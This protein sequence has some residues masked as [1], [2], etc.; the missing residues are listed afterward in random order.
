MYHPSAPDPPVVSEV[1]ATSCTV[2]YQP[3]Q[4]DSG[5]PVTGYILERRT[6]GPDSDW[7]TVSDTPVTDLHYIIDNLTPATEYEFRVAAVNKKWMGYFSTVSQRIMT[8]VKP[9]KPGRPE[10]IGVIG[11]SVH[12]QW[13]APE[14]N[15]GADITEYRVMFETSDETED[16]TVAADANTESLMSCIVR[17]QL[18]THTEYRFAVAAVNRTGQGPQSDVSEYYTTFGGMLN[19]TK[20]NFNN[21][22]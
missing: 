18:K 12:L 8:L 5:A 2:T 7:I 20:T 14:S 11:T 19:K 1:H 22:C 21:E 3:P 9:D 16:I 10:V 13:T 15:G 6:R 4:D 17:N